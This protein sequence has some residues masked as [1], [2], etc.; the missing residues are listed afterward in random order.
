MS[1]ITPLYI[2]GQEVHS[3]TGETFE[4]RNPYSQQVVGISASASKDDC[5]SAITAA[6]NAFKTWEHSSVDQRRNI[7][8]KAADIFDSDKYKKMIFQHVAEETAAS[9]AMAMHNWTGAGKILRVTA[10]LLNLLRGES[11][12]SE[13]TNASVIAQRRAMGVMWVVFIFR[14]HRRTNIAAPDSR[15]HPGMLLSSSHCVQ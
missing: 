6:G 14:L 7:F 5:L 1:P 12:P 2:N 3:S 11:F 15:F 10:G 9:P 13:R 4:V 8:M